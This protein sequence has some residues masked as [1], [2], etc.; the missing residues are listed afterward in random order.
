M[1]TS[2][3]SVGPA[4]RRS[5][6]RRS[7]AVDESGDEILSRTTTPSSPTKARD[8]K[9]CSSA[10]TSNERITSSPAPSDELPQ[11]RVLIQMR[12]SLAR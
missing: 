5:S 10:A 6:V 3:I 1:E 8:E 9:R 4:P 7:C 2:R 11:L 12:R